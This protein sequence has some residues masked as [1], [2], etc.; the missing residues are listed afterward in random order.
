MAFFSRRQLANYAAEQI[1]DNNKNIALELTSYLYETNR[2]KEVDSLIRDIDTALAEKGVINAEI[3][4]HHRLDNS[5]RENL[6]AVLSK[7]YGSD[8][9]NID[10]SIDASL[11]GGIKIKTACEEF[12]GSLRYK[13]NRL[14]A[15]KA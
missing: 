13:I 6:K 2:I 1:L 11:L 4:S 10:E 7:H 8:S 3:S 9:I 14:K 5:T 12:D 15:T